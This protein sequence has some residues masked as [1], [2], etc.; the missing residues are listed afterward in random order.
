M[1]QNAGG[2]ARKAATPRVIGGERRLHPGLIGIPVESRPMSR[3]LRTV[4]FGVG[5]GLGLATTYSVNAALQW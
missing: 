5:V 3:V 4:H 1:R 2:R